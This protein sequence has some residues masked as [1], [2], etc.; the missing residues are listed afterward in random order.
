MAISSVVESRTL[1]RSRSLVQIQYSQQ[2]QWTIVERLAQLTD[3]QLIP[4]RVWIVQ[5]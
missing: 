4:V 3:T 1:I 5:H 2:K